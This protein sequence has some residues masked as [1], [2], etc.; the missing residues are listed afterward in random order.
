MLICVQTP[1][2]FQYI[3]ELEAAQEQEQHTSQV[4]LPSASCYS[5]LL[6]DETF[7]NEAA[8]PACTSEEQEGRQQVLQPHVELQQWR[9]SV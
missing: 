1:L 2:F 4:H 9:A 7:D 3:A 8:V 6:A 5:T